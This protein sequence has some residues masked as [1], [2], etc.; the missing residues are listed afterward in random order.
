MKRNLII[1]FLIFFSS[2]MLAAQND[3]KIF[4][5]KN[6]PKG[7]FTQWGGCASECCFSRI[8]TYF[9]EDGNCVQQ[10]LDVEH[11]KLT[12]L[13]KWTLKDS[14]VNMHFT[15]SRYGKGIGKTFADDN[16]CGIERYTLYTAIKEDVDLHLSMTLGEIIQTGAFFYEDYLEEISLEAKKN[17]AEISRTNFFATSG[18]STTNIHTQQAYSSTYLSMQNKIQLKYLRNQIFAQYGYVFKNKE[19]NDYFKGFIWYEPL[20]SDVSAYLTECD[21]ANVALI[22]QFEK[23]APHADVPEALSEIDEIP[24]I[25]MVYVKGSSFMMGC[26]SEE[27]TDC[28]YN[29]NENSRKEKV[30][31][32]YI[33]KYE[34]TQAQWKAIMGHN[35]SSN[36]GDDLPVE[37]VNW[38]DVQYFIQRLNELTGKHYRL[39]AEEEWEYA[40]RGGMKSKRYKYSGSNMADD[41]AWYDTKI[42]NNTT[43]RVGV[44]TPNE[45]GIYDMSG[46]VSEMCNGHIKK[47]VEAKDISCTYRGGGINNDLKELRLSRRQ[48]NLLNQK[49]RYIGFRLACNI[50]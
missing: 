40:A 39:P 36:I 20:Y 33:G 44:K 8:S 3:L 19:I 10:F 15:T 49:N 27:E 50:K 46:N 47:S 30:N 11:D 28:S 25:E 31:D 1:S 9:Y 37:N 14:V 21:H 24:N 45:L 4:V 48:D 29:R 22:K 2:Y 41:V 34:V 13:G 5:L 26:T 35:P 18:Y 6:G 32:F 7:V 23:T 17:K 42:A 16:R 43:I 38:Y 12:Y